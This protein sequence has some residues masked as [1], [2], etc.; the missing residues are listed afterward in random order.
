MIHTPVLLDEVLSV[1]RGLKDGVVVDC[2]LGYSGHSSALLEQN[3]DINLIGCDR[4]ETAINY[5]KKKLEKYKDRVQIYHSAF[6]E[7]LSK[8]EI[9]EIRAI[10]ADIGVSSLQLDR[11]DRGFSLN[12]DTLDMRMDRDQSKDAKFIVNSYSV[13]ELADIFWKY[14]ELKDANFIAKKIV[15]AREKSEITSAKELVDIIGLAPVRKGGI[16]KATLA[17]QALRIEVN[18]ELVELTTL[19]TN[20]KNLGLTNCLVAVITFHSLEDRIVKNTFKEW[21]KEC[22]CPEFFMRCECGGKNALGEIVTKKA[23]TASANEIAQNSRSR[24]A[25]LRVFK[26][27]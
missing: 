9:S 3:R 16:S 6:S 22:V 26:I 12:S 20:I 23:I 2:T 15:D 27:K 25:K 8:L 19:L 1:F 4:D 13:D 21:S 5:S 11:N 17:F 18:D 14:G 10:L 7:I 24:P